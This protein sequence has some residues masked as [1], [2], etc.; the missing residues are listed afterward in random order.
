MCTNYYII[1]L[2]YFHS[3]AP[4]SPKEVRL[5]IQDPNQ[6]IDGASEGTRGRV[7]VTVRSWYT[8][9][10]SQVTYK[11]FKEFVSRFFNGLTSSEQCSFLI[12][13][14]Y[15]PPVRKRERAGGSSSSAGP[16]KRDRGMHSKR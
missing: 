4:G 11:L 1:I 10:A 9:P 3:G 8:S 14:C 13:V 16:S 7:Q 6:H 15:R 12:D 2:G 5:Q